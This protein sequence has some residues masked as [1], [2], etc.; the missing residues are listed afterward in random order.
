M[1]NTIN[2][3]DEGE[4]LRS[5]LEWQIEGRERRIV[6]CVETAL[7]MRP[8]FPGFDPVRLEALIDEA[9]KLMHASASPIDSIRIV[10][11]H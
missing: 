1:S 11:Q 8:G 5:W 2:P 10:P 7:E 3:V 4:T 6:L 9:T